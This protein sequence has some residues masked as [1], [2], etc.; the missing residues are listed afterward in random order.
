[1][2]TTVKPMS[3]AHARCLAMAYD[4]HNLLGEVYEEPG[5]SS[6]VERAWEL[7]D[8]VIS[9]LEP[10]EP[11]SDEKQTAHS[12][13]LLVTEPREYEAHRNGQAMRRLATK[14]RRKS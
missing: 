8:Q 3:A 4:L 7:V 13:R 12:L 9:Y 11:D 14:P 2:I 1:M 10:E 6:C 5:A